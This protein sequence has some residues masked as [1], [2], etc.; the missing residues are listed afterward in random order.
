M[1]R[2][3]PIARPALPIRRAAAEEA[4][5]DGDGPVELTFDVVRV[6][7]ATEAISMI[8]ERSDLEQTLQSTDGEELALVFD[9][10]ELERAIEGSE[11]EAQGLRE[12]AAVLTVAVAAMAGSAGVASAAAGASGTGYVV[13]AG[14]TEAI[15]NDAGAAGGASGT[16]YVVP[17]GGTEAIVNDAGAAGGASGTGYVVPAGGTEAIVN[18]AGAAGGASGTGY[19]VP[20]GGTEAIVNDAGAAGGASGTGY[21]VPAGGTE[22][23]VNDAGAAGASGT[24]YVVPAGGTE[25]QSLN[26]AGGRHGSNAS[27]T[28]YVV[29]AGGTEAIVN[30]AVLR[31]SVRQ[32]RAGCWRRRRAVVDGVRGTRGRRDPAR[33]R[34]RLRGDADEAA[35]GHGRRRSGVAMR[36]GARRPPPPRIEPLPL[37][38]HSRGARAGS[39]LG[40][41]RRRHASRSLG[42]DWVLP[43]DLPEP[44]EVGVG[45]ADA[46]SVFDREGRLVGDEISAQSCGA[47]RSAAEVGVALGR[48]GIH[49]GSAASQR[50]TCLDVVAG[51]SGLS[52]AREISADAQERHQRLPREC[53]APLSA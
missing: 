4:L 27:G 29:P 22:A 25:A 47:M 51:V 14:G 6:G 46:E 8:L 41:G 37:E 18:D 17:A 24:G 28:G 48:S 40:N 2:Q 33:R 36:Q 38:K 30:D 35:P 49:A 50:S 5:R 19:V 10:D 16:G 44:R 11:V 7:G 21:V 32:C 23:I 13:P 12:T 9:P 45:E 31:A 34:R 26:D 52:T 43:A 1:P 53:G 42:A 39:P 3:V 15:V 20:A